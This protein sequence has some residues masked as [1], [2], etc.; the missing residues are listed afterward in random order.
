MS[1]VKERDAFGDDA[2]LFSGN[3]F[4][5]TPGTPFPL[6]LLRQNTICLL[7]TPAHPTRKLEDHGVRQS[8][9]TKEDHPAGLGFWGI[10]K[11]VKG[12]SLTLALDIDHGQETG[13]YFY[14]WYPETGNA[15]YAMPETGARALLYFCCAGKQEGAV[16]HCLNKD[17]EENRCYEDRAFSIEDGNVI[18]LSNE[19]ICFSR[20]G[21]HELSLDD[22]LI[23]TSTSGALTITAKGKVRLK[24]K[25]IM[26]NTSEELNLCQG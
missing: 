4:P 14:P 24:A 10:I 6:H 20:G 5:D 18:D 22:S 16:I 19:A 9:P 15:L 13:D 17:S 23:S 26:I 25:Q 11:K 8:N 2:F 7:A 1:H 12:E 3:A 21:G